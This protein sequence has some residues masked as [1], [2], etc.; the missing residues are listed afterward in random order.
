MPLG[1]TNDGDA[2]VFKITSPR[3]Q[4]PVQGGVNNFT[5][6]SNTRSGGMQKHGVM[7]NQNTQPIVLP[8]I[9]GMMGGKFL[10][11]INNLMPYRFICT[12]LWYAWT[13]V[14]RRITELARLDGHCI[15]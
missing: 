11:F 12:S 9:G 6:N 15:E 7:Y 1:H 5:M 10:Y 13:G 14:V 2:N 4:I 8:P 3:Y